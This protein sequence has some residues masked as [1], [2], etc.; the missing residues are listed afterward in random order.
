MKT[1]IDLQVKSLFL[2]L[3]TTFKQASSVRSLGESI[4]CK[5]QRGEIIG[6]GEGCPRIYVTNET[7]ETALDWIHQKL[8]EIQNEC[9][10][11]DSLKNWMN[12]NREEIDEHPAAFCAI[13]TALLDLFSKEKNINV[14]KLLGLESPERVFTYTGVLSDGGEEK[15]IAHA[16]RFL[17]GGFTD[18]KIKV[19]GDLKIDRKKF[20]LLFDL[21]KKYN[22]SNLRIRLDANNLWKGKVEEAIAHLAALNS[23]IFGIE[24]PVAPKNYTALSQISKELD[25]SIILDESLC[26]FS[27]FKKLDQVSGK[28]IGNL[29]VSRLGGAIRSFEIIEALKK[30]NHQI[31]VGAHVGETSILTRAGMCV[32][33]AA[34]KNLVAQEGGF[35][36]ILLEKDEVQ[37]SLNFGKLGQIDLSKEKGNWNYGWGF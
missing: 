7:A 35:G 11:L 4:W 37:P 31:I 24:E 10:S 6:L 23:P 16:S 34:G 17:Q 19:N 9:H 28:F 20:E 32:S 12:E 8:S 26:A 18:F 36:E 2:P 14:E 30:R 33:Q 15:F 13:E 1:P 5:V 27:D 29:K 22:V 21:A 25:V 3:R